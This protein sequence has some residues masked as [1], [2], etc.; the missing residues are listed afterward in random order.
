MP[1]EFV[2]VGGGAAGLAAADTI[3]SASGDNYVQLFEAKGYTGG[4]AHTDTRSIPGLPFD[5]GAVYLQDPANNPWTQAAKELGF[6]TIPD[7][8]GAVMRID[9]GDGYK[10]VPPD[11]DDAVNAVVKEIAADYERNKELPNRPVMK[12]P[13]L[14]T[15]SEWFGLATSPYG[16]FTE[17]AEPWQYLAA[18]RAR[19]AQGEGNRFVKEGL[20]NLVRAYGQAL[21]ERFNDRYTERLA[22]PV[23]EIAQEKDAVVVYTKEHQVIVPATA[24]VVTAS[25]DVLAAGIITF[26]PALP[27]AYVDA[28]KALRLGSY[29]KLAVE[30]A[31]LPDGIEDNTNYYLYNS[32]PEGIWQYYRL[33]YFPENVLVVHASGDFA[34][35]LDT[36][37]DR[38]VYRL[39]QSALGE[40]Y[41]VDV[42]LR[43]ARAITNWRKDPYVRGA[44]SY[45]AFIGGGPEDRSALAARDVLSKPVGRVCF[46]G[47]AQSLTA[48]GTLQGAYW[49]GQAAARRA[50]RMA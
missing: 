23:T 18:D 22:T 36:V 16:P 44:Y 26:T 21:Q 37:E 17:S 8:M 4:R 41:G 24:C 20:G 32:E 30:L 43:E 47:E 6:E 7:D 1:K 9:R 19:D 11:G 49:E 29:K 50:L 14:D 27:P 38:M 15:V 10:D 34:A 48:Y 31:A 5:M 12:K 28:L 46:G 39:F 40:A 42:H 45:T 35:A 2:I 13:R 3:L 33:S 25:V